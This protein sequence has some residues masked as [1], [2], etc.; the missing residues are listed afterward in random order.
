MYSSLQSRPGESN[1]AV[2]YSFHYD[3]D[4]LECN[5][6]RKSEFYKGNLFW[7]LRNGKK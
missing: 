6:S 3:N 4:V 7:I 1:M 5:S 2:F